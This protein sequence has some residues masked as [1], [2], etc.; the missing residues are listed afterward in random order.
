M[1]LPDRGRD[2]V[3]VVMLLENFYYPQDVRVREEAESLAAAGYAVEVIAPRARGQQPAEIVGPVKVKRFREARPKTAS[4]VAF[5]IEYV[6]AV[7]ALHFHA[8]RAL[9][10]GARVLH[11]HNPPDL[12]FPAAALFR[13][14]GRQVV[15]DHH[16]LF[17]EMV[18]VKT[19]N[20]R[21]AAVARI[22]ERLTY[23]AA[24]HVLATNESYADIARTRGRKRD[25][26]VTVVRNGPPRAWLEL[27]PARPGNGG[28]REQLRIGYL[29]E[30]SD[31]DGVD[32]LI[33]LL[34]RIR[35]QGVDARLTIIGDGD[36]RPRLEQSAAREGLGELVTFTG[37]LD[38]QDVPELLA[39]M[40]V[41]VDPAPATE[42]NDR[43]TMTKIA[44]YLCVG[45]PVVAYDLTETRRTAENAAA[46]V[47]P[48]DA[49]GFAAAVVALAGDP[50]R[51][52]LYSALARERARALSW[53]HS[54]LELLG[55]YRRLIGAAARSETDGR[56][57][58]SGQAQ[59]RVRS[60]QS[61]DSPRD[62]RHALGRL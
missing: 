44:E 45:C 52:R 5:V 9:L 37:W 55:A 38:H 2:R 10:R 32:E 12:L 47:T 24:D 57:Q 40:D 14:V 22:A 6:V 41:C 58:S 21:L 19:G 16:D 7:P 46:L 28:E 20:R 33:P 23:K 39:R 1:R 35:R 18:H 62:S 29:G 4:I 8:L 48:G 31:H 54:E 27:A 50:E 26:Q 60:Q 11:L 43:S 61:A 36:A 51:R 49:A 30:L 42:L 17:P 56:G 3:R 59:R 25:D 34:V 15:F 13:L 53:S